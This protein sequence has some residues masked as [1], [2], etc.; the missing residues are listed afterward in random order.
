MVAVCYVYYAGDCLESTP[1]ELSINYE[2]RCGE[3]KNEYIL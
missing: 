2:L 1:L 3:I